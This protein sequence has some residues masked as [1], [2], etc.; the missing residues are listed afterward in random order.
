MCQLSCLAAAL[1]SFTSVWSQR[2]YNFVPAADWSGSPGQ[3]RTSI[4]RNITNF[5]LRVKI[6]PELITVKKIEV[7][8][9][10]FSKMNEWNLFCYFACRRENLNFDVSMKQIIEVL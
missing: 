2:W 4:D 5:L 9:Q 8:Q 7:V 6:Y 10:Y 1:D 3:L